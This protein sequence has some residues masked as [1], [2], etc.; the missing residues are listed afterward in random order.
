MERNTQTPHKGLQPV[1]GSG[2][3][4]ISDGAFQ[5]VFP[6]L[7]VAQ[8][9]RN[10]ALGMRAQGPPGT[11]ALTGKLH[12]CGAAP[13]FGFLASPSVF[14]YLWM[15]R[16]GL[17]RLCLGVHEFTAQNKQHPTQLCARRRHLLG[18]KRLRVPAHT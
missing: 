13:G 10:G 12:T 11:A 6:G 16:T 17:A 4:W 14:V 15:R 7:A 2:P 1:L 8:C 18:G 5:L 3:G 9:G